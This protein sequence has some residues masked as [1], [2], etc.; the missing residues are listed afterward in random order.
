M[1]RLT[2]LAT[3]LAAALAAV[4]VPL[5]AEETL[6]GGVRTTEADWDGDWIAGNYR[7]P[8]GGHAGLGDGAVLE[9]LAVIMHEAGHQFGYENPHGMS[10]GC[11]NGDRCHDHYGSGSIMSHDDRIRIGVTPEDVERVRISGFEAHYH[12]DGFAT[13]RDHAFSDWGDFSYHMDCTA[14]GCSGDGVESRWYAGSD[15]DP[16]GMRA[17]WW[18]MP[19]MPMSVPS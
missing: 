13:W 18:T 3:V 1:P 16:T 5:Q 2:T 4:T 17:A 15:G 19:P 14:M 8:V 7:K 10:E 12:E 6:W 9:L 11:G